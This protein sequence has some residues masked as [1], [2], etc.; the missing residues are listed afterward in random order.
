MLTNQRPIDAVDT[1]KL[2]IKKLL[3]QHSSIKNGSTQTKDPTVSIST[4][5]EAKLRGHSTKKKLNESLG[6]QVRMETFDSLIWTA[7]KSDHPAPMKRLVLFTDDVSKISFENVE[8]MRHTGLQANK[9]NCGPAATAA[10]KVKGT[11]PSSS[12]ATEY[13]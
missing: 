12:T 13:L 11:N 2:D 10:D 6:A 5:H 1:L 3:E 7:Q 9:T 8:L 4:F